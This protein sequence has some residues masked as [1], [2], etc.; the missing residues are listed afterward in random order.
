[1]SF[2]WWHNFFGIQVYL[3]FCGLIIF[4]K[5]YIWIFDKKNSTTMVWIECD[6]ETWSIFIFDHSKHIF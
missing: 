3:F 1:M 5:G 4:I 6:L 2:A